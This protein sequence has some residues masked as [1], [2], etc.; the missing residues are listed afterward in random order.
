[1]TDFTMELRLCD[2][3][4]MVSH[5]TA[6]DCVPTKSYLDKLNMLRRHTKPF[7][8]HRPVDEPFP[9]TGS[10]HL[11]GEHI[12][13]TSPAHDAITYQKIVVGN[14]DEYIAGRPINGWQVSTAGVPA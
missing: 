1:M 9:C 14:G 12:R 7:D 3:E 10:A 2:D 11:A 13:C 8:E 6:P 4:G 5:E